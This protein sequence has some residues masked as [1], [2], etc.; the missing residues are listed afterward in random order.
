MLNNLRDSLKPTL[1][2]VGKTFAAT[3]LSPNVFTVIGLI[4]AFV[5]SVVYGLGYEYSLAIG[6]VIL[7]ISGFF[8]IVDG[9]VARYANKINSYLNY[10]PF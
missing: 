5:S 10:R 2:K 7:L 1:E 3:G 9:Q 6:G 8:D 4:F